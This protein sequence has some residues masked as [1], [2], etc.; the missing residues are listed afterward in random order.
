MRLVVRD[1]AVVPDP[2][3]SLPGRGAWIHQDR[4]CVEAAIRRR[5]FG[6]AFRLTA[7]LDTRFLAEVGPNRGP[8]EEQADQPMDN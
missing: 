3:A 6:R 2:K 5:A 1:G 7:P 4:E 8:T